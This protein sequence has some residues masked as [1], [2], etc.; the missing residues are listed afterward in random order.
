MFHG[1]CGGPILL[2]AMPKSCL[3]A[4]TNCNED[5]FSFTETGKQ[6]LGRVSSPKSFSLRCIQI[7]KAFALKRQVC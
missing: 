4:M 7:F 3:I 5:G 6:L 2:V 1:P